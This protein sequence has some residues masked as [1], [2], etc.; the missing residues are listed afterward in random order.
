M[1]EDRELDF[2]NFSLGDGSTR[3]KQRRL[4]AIVSSMLNDPSQLKVCKQVINK[5]KKER[6]P[7]FNP[8]VS[9]D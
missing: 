9:I 7:K 5:I 3:T 8:M 6:V 2:K 1:E 4:D